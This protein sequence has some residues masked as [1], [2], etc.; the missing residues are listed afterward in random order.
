MYDND[1]F[2]IDE[3]LR[4]GDSER[5]GNIKV[6]Y[7]VPNTTY[8]A[9]EICREYIHK[10]DNSKLSAKKL[11]EILVNEK[12]IYIT[13]SIPKY[14]LFDDTLGIVYEKAIRYKE[15]GVMEIHKIL[16]KMGYIVVKKTGTYENIYQFL[17]DCEELSNVTVIAKD[18]TNISGRFVLPAKINNILK[19]KGILKEDGHLSE[20]CRLL[21]ENHIFKQAGEQNNFVKYNKLGKLVIF[22]ILLDY[23]YYP[24]KI[25]F[26]FI[27]KLLGS[28]VY[29]SLGLQ[30][31]IDMYNNGLFN[32][33]NIDKYIKD[34]Y[35]K[36]LSCKE[37]IQFY[38]KESDNT[39]LYYNEFIRILSLHLIDGDFFYP[40]LYNNEFTARFNDCGSIVKKDIYL[41]DKGLRVVHNNLRQAGY[42]LNTNYNI[43]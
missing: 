36:P 10:D 20:S 13:D 26:D 18:Y 16:D 42:I 19:E 12:I 3:D 11:N 8:N 28:H 5:Y 34:V 30:G 37:V 9:V 24:A 22:Y 7:Y 27:S 1:D 4:F 38:K 23:G 33:N 43:G 14:R 39:P 29:E 2:I 41:N 31:L 32:Y 6:P 40:V 15:K 17:S 35:I 25:E 21:G